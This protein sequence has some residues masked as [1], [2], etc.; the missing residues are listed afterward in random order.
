MV[1]E[2]AHDLCNQLTVIN[3][4][5]GHVAALLRDA[6][7]SAITTDLEMLKRAAEEAT[8][9]AKRLAQLLGEPNPLLSGHSP[10]ALQR[11]PC[12]AKPC[13]YSAPRLTSRVLGW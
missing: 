12:R 11:S 3:L 1:N 7:D 2:L 6:G 13:G 5:S 10:R 9:L 8:R 4:C